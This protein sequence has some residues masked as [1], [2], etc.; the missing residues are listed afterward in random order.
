MPRSVII[1]LGT[2]LYRIREV[3]PLTAIALIS[4]M[5]HNK[6][7]SQTGKFPFFLIY[8]QS[9]GKVVFTSMAPGKGYSKQQKKVDMVMKEHRDIFSSPIGVPLHCKVKH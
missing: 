7:I 6:V 3:A 2:K 9:K 4:D 8:S 5:Q 1:S